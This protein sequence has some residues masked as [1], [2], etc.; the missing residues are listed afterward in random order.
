[1]A[2]QNPTHA[3]VIGSI[4]TTERIDFS[5]GSI[6]IGFLY[7]CTLWTSRKSLVK[8]VG[9]DKQIAYITIYTPDLLCQSEGGSVNLTIK[10]QIQS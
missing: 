8:D 6:N 2:K 5:T 3:G 7:H 1:M 10:I 4:P 9:C